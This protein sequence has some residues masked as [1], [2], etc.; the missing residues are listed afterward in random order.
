MYEQYIIKDKEQL[1]KIK[2]ALLA[3]YFTDYEQSFLE[4]KTGRQDIDANVYRRYNNA[5]KY[6]VPWVARVI[7]LQQKDVLEIGSGTGS[8][9]A[10]FAHF[11][12]KIDGYDIDKHA[13]DGARARID[14]MEIEN[15]DFHLVEP[16]ALVGTL[17]KNHSSGVDIILLYAV[18]EHQTIRER[19][20]TITLCWDILKP[21]GLLV[22]NETPNL[23]CYMDSH[24]SVLPFMHLLPSELY[25]RYAE[26]S[27]R[28]RFNSCFIDHENTSLQDLDTSIM[29]WARGVSFHDFEL[30]L[31]KNHG[32]YLVA[33]GFEAE[34]M[35]WF[36]I[37]LEEE[38]LR[39]YVL[40]NEL[41]IQLSYTR[42]VLTVI[43][44]KSNDI[45]TCHDDIPENSFIS[46][47]SVVKDQ[48]GVIKTL[49]EDLKEKESQ[50]VNILSS[51]RWLIGNILAIPYRKVKTI[52]SN[53]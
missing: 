33:S 12:Q 15:V 47:R 22:V 36:G 53:H 38:L 7:D 34:M 4:T 5:L 6:V 11:V 23:L 41:N 18:L 44:K 27:P 19:Q 45:E 2:E 46:G 24:T 21:G 10:A 40:K 32:Q 28:E 8:S 39:Y 50:L 29:R 49:R 43:Y 37:S 48:E 31:G 30:A 13:V 3:T 52:L 20:E 1:V 25:A 51:R 42:T 9:T 14:V 35:N 16:E 26:H 17:K